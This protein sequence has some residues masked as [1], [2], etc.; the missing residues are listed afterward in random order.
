MGGGGQDH[1][2]MFATTPAS[3]SYSQIHIEHFKDVWWCTVQTY[4]ILVLPNSWRHPHREKPPHHMSICVE[5][6]D[7]PSSTSGGRY[8]SVTTSLE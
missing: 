4:G 7:E 1:E 3:S 2:D 5:Y 8:H 6:S